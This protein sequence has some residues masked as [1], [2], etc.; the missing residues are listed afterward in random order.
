MRRLAVD[1]PAVIM[2]GL[3]LVV[4]GGAVLEWRFDFFGGW[5]RLETDRIADAVGADWFAW[6]AAGA[7]LVLAVLAVWW[8]LA[9]IPR[10]VEGRVPLAADGADRIEVDVRS[11][12]PKLR[13]DFERAAPVDHVTGRRRR[14]GSGQLIELRANVDPRADGASLLRAAESLTDSVAEAFPDGEVAVRLLIDP[15]RRPGAR[16]TPRVH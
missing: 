14:T 7:A 3:L 2:L 5:D 10:G 16:K 15:P 1:R 12:V 6:A 8:L 13:A 11:I 9:R 4:L